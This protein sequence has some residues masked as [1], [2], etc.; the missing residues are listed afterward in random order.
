MNAEQKASCNIT[1]HRV[2]DYSDLNVEWILLN[3]VTANQLHAHK[4]F[5]VCEG[6]GGGMMMWGCF[7]VT[8]GT[9]T[10][11]VYNR[12]P[13]VNLGPSVPGLKLKDTC[14]IQ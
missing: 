3:W 12:I 8:D 13:K 2:L 6:S 7:V 4:H 9:L 11:A 14:F 10:S 1:A 5:K